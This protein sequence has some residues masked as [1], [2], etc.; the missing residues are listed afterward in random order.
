MN[1][2]VHKVRSLSQKEVPGGSVMMWL[3]DVHIPIHHRPA[4][5]LAIECAEVEGVTHV[6]PGGDIFDFNCL[7][8]HPKDP[9]RVLDAGTI[10]EEVEPGRDILNWFATRTSYFLW[11]NH[12]NR[13]KRFIAKDGIALYGGPAGDLA[14]MT[15]L[16]AAI[17]VIPEETELRLGNL[18]LTHGHLEFG[19]GTGGKYPAQRLLD[20]APDQSTI[21]GHV[22]RYSYANR[23]SRD[24]NGVLRTRAAT[25]MPH[26]SIEERHHGYAGKHPN[27]QMGFGIIRVWYEGN[28]P[29]WHVYPVE[30]LFDRRNRPYFEFN[31]K[32]YR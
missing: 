15:K 16:P 28:R 3:S 26:M 24:E 19:K 20:M 10:L 32:V 2:A 22:H 4:L 9:D 11:G 25:T 13:L 30:V 1:S 27:W 31:G 6:V 7:S 12:E 14:A 23:T 29:R 8:Q 17:E 18:V 21:A 5:E